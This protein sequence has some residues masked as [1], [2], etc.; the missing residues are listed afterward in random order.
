MP[1]PVHAPLQP[2]KVEPA[3]GVAVRVIGV[4][5]S[6]TAEQFA[7]VS[8]QSK[9]P[10]L[11]VTLPRPVP[12]LATVRVNVCGLKVAVTDRA[13]LIVTVHGPVPVHAPPQP[14]KVEP[15]AGVA[16]KVIG[17]PLSYTAEQ[18]AAVSGQSKRPALEV[19]LP[20]PVPAL[21]TVRV[22]C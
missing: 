10:A 15:A 20:R 4:P 18:F 16:V 5:L 3:A 19:T 7:A 2:P 6:Y 12:A 17:V 14:P 13:A 11:E 21:A 8:G 1:V 22:N 9:R